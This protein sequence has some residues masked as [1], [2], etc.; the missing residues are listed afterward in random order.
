MRPDSTAFAVEGRLEL[1][2][3]R[4][5]TAVVSA[6]GQRLVVDVRDWKSC[7]ALVK[8]LPRGRDRAR[9]LRIAQASLKASGL[10]LEFD[11]RGVTIARMSGKGRGSMFA[12]FVGWPGVDVDLVSLAR[13]RMRL[14]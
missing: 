6:S 12:R 14:V 13:A 2:L 8:T 1:A 10:A 7:R 11:L 5:P 3:D 4:I 9:M